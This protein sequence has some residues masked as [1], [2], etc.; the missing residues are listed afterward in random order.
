MRLSFYSGLALAVI[1]ADNARVS[2]SSD[3]QDKGAQDDF[4]LGQVEEIVQ[5]FAPEFKCTTSACQ[6]DA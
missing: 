6:A 5:D 2:A 3:V 1:A 4:K